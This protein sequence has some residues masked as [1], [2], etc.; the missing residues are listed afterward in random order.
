MREKARLEPRYAELVYDGL[1]YSPLKEA[2]DA[3][4]DATPAL[5]DRR[6]AAAARAG[7]LLRRRP[8]RRHALYDYGLATYDADDTFRH[9][10]SEG[11]VRLWGS[12]LRDVGAAPSQ[13]CG[14]A[15]S[16]EQAPCGTGG[17]ATGP[18]DELLAFT[19]SLPFDRAARGRRPRGLARR[20]CDG[21]P[22]SGCSTAT[23]PRRSS[24]ALDARRGRA[25]RRHVRVRADRRGHPHRDRAPGHRDRRRRR[26]RSCTPAAAATTRSRPTCGSVR[27][28][29]RCAGRAPRPS[30]SSRCSLDRAERGRRRLPPGL[31]PPAAR[32][33]GAARAPPA[34]ALLGARPRR[35]S[36]AATARA[37]AD[38]SPLGRG[39]ARRFVACRSIPHGTAADL[40]FAAAFENSLDAVSRPRLR[41]RGAVRPRARSACTCRG[42]AR[43]SCCG[44][45]SEFGF[46]APRRRV[47]HRSLDAAAEEEPRHRRARA[48]QGRPARSA[49]SPG[50]SRRSRACRSRTTATCRR[51]RSRCSTRSTQPRSRCAR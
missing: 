13:G 42:S 22:G 46:A 35:R 4:V 14:Q 47:R 39:R 9:E 15:A 50:S 25:R 20:T 43:R 23:R 40:G 8:A 36:L 45:P 38:V 41:R 1:W 16:R 3:F 34:R 7:P 18:A 21:S 19:V 10:D 44:R 37:A 11:F 48:G 2:F 32:A 29:E 33:A 17:S 27:K 28:R 30:R 51:T 49:T 24:R 26:R 12:R 6:G 31:H 5:R